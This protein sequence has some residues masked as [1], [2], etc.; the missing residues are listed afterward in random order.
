MTRLPRPAARPTPPPSGGPLK[1]A[2]VVL[3]SCGLVWLLV[4][5]TTP[6]PYPPRVSA[7]RP[8]AATQPMRPA[9][10]QAYVAER[11]VLGG[12]A[13]AE[14]A[15]P[16]SREVSVDLDP[17]PPVPPV[18]VPPPVPTVQVSARVNPVAEPRGAVATPAFTAR[19]EHP[20]PSRDAAVADAI[21]VARCKLAEKLQALD[22]PVTTL[23]SAEVVRRHA[24]PAKDKVIRPTDDLIARGVSPD[25]VWAEVEVS[26][27]SAAEVREL[28]AEGRLPAVGLLVLLPLLVAGAAHGFLRFDAWTKG[29]LTAAAA[30]VAVAVGVGG[31]LVLLATVR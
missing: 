26:G 24:D 28:R 25:L 9:E 27:L 8:A 18:V 3:V 4:S 15:S 7:P 10:L 29:Y 31:V 17:L 21:S 1:T 19:S 2:A 14:A 12:A 5:S 11:A 22:P 20:H 30:A 6:R 23:P 16:A 13:V